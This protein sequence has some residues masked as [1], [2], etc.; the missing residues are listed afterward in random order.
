MQN[1]WENSLH[2]YHALTVVALL[3]SLKKQS[4]RLVA[5]IS[6][7]LQI[8]NIPIQMSLILNVLVLSYNW[9]S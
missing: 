5:L 6:A 8:K 7:Q 2:F 1:W 4:Y 9:F 3:W